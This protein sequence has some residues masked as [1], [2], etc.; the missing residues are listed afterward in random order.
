MG[1]CDSAQT[2]ASPLLYFR[3]MGSPGHNQISTIRIPDTWRG[4]DRFT[5]RV[6]KTVD[7]ARLKFPAKKKKPVA[8]SA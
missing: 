4:L 1:V 7:R 3:A 6:C 8:K 5:D 2:C